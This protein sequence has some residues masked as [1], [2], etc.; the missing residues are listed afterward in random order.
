MR[1]AAYL[2][3]GAVG[4]PESAILYSIDSMATRGASGIM[5]QPHW[6]MIG[7]LQAV[8]GTGHSMGGLIPRML[9][10]IRQLLRAAEVS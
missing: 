7:A 3:L 10:G 6:Q 4:S 5:L 1:I 2:W 8:D 9:G